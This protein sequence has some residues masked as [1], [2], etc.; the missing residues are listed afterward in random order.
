M[1]PDAFEAI[2]MLVHLCIT[3]KDTKDFHQGHKDLSSIIMDF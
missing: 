1:I 2:I 3:T